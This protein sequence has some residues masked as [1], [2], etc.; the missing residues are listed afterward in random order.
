MARPGSRIYYLFSGLMMI[1]GT[2][3]FMN[4]GR[5]HP[6]INESMGQFGTP[7]FFYKF[8][9]LIAS[10]ANWEQVHAFII[11]GPVLWALGLLALAD[12]LRVNGESRWSTFALVSL[13]MGVTLHVVLYIFDGFV[14]SKIATQLLNSDETLRPALTA[15]FGA[16]QWT[17]IRMSTVSWLLISIAPAAIAL[18][19]L[20]ARRGLGAFGR[21]L[22][23][24]LVVVGL[25]L[26]AFGIVASVTGTYSPGPMVSPFYV[27]VA[28]TTAL[29]FAVAGL[30][31]M[32]RPSTPE[33]TP[34]HRAE[35][36]AVEQAAVEPQR[37][38]TR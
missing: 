9:S 22:Q 7:D 26:G 32:L 4:G 14:A 24:I 33:T 28:V 25:V 13:A 19:M 20:F 31:V 5:Q 27:P 18:S 37:V 34:S 8:A 23:G 38:S 1:A 6:P 11:I 3:I 15:T 35:H 29:W 36:R 12:Q 17:V 21:V 30:S 10:D 16:N 2:V